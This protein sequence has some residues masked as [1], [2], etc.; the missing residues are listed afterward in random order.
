MKKR[1]SIDIGSNSILLLVAEFDDGKIKIVENESNVTGLGRDLDKNGVFIDEAMDESFSVFMDYAE[2][3]KKHGLYLEDVVVTATEASR[4]ATNAQNYFEKIKR[5]IGF[6]V[7]IITGEAEAY[8]STTGILFDE[9]IKDEFITIMDIGGASTELIRVNV[10]KKEIIHSFSMPVG[11]VRMNNWKLEGTL[12]KNLGSVLQNFKKDIECV[13][14]Q[15]LFCVAGTMTSV[16]NI[17]LNNKNFNESQVNGLEFKC[18]EVETMYIKYRDITSDEFLK[19]F[20]FL[21]KRSKTIYSGIVLAKNILD[22]LESSDVYIST[23]GLRYGT[24]LAGE[25]KND[26]IHGP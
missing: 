17:Y 14:A 19:Q 22:K 11:A 2:I 25:I 10:P 18:M 13:K 23:F 3:C 21:G 6:D 20:P 4:V 24:L 15:K 12:A 7:K 9:K 1:A 5:D 26:F 16:G 8:Y